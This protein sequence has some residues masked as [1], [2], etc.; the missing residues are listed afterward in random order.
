MLTVIIEMNYM[1]PGN[2][3]PSLSGELTKLMAGGPM[4]EAQN[5]LLFK[6]M[7]GTGPLRQSL[8]EMLYLGVL[9]EDTEIQIIDGEEIRQPIMRIARLPDEKRICE[10]CKRV[11]NDYKWESCNGIE[12][13]KD[14]KGTTRTVGKVHKRVDTKWLNWKPPLNDRGFPVIINSI[15]SNVH[16][17]MSTANLKKNFD[18]I[19]VSRGL[20]ADI[21]EMIYEHDTGDE[22][23]WAGDGAHFTRAWRT[24]LETTIASNINAVLTR[25][26]LGKLLERLTQSTQRRELDVDRGGGGSQGSG[27]I[28]DKIGQYFTK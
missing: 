19:G 25:S 2:N 11:R 14:I 6:E 27:G 24:H 28:V 16:Q 26:D 20:A 5:W 21:D 13:V 3:S 10:I 18:S 15:M 7:L 1:E 22:D 8:L 4:P 9:K 23:T 12:R 17:A